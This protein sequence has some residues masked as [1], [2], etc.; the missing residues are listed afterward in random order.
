MYK[1]PEEMTLKDA[2]QWSFLKWMS[3]RRRDDVGTISE[4]ETGYAIRATQSQTADT[5]T[6]LFFTTSFWRNHLHGS[7]AALLAKTRQTATFEMAY[8]PDRWVQYG[9][10]LALAALA[11]ML[12]ENSLWCSPS[13]IN[14]SSFLNSP[15]REK[16]E[17]NSYI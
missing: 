5:R 9:K 1:R 6:V 14:Q 13:I 11:I 10:K 12:R 2:R 4:D 8:S 3:I 7:E 16:K 17:Q 15:N